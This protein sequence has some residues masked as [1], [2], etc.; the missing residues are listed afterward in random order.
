[1]S[2]LTTSKLSPTNSLFDVAP[3]V[4]HAARRRLKPH[5]SGWNNLCKFL[6]TDPSID[7]LKLLTMMEF[8]DAQPRQKI[9][10]NII[11]KLNSKQR[12]RVMDAFTLCSKKS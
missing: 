8:E 7:D 1:M 12:K 3:R 6:A 4:T 5:L 2:P 10:E 9:V 11:G